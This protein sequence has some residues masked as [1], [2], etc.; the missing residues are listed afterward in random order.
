MH[1][2]PAVPSALGPSLA[3]ERLSFAVDEGEI[4]DAASRLDARECADTVQHRVEERRSLRGGRVAG[5]DEAHF[6]RQ[7][8]VAIEAR[9]GVSERQQA[10]DHHSRAH[11]QHD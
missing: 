11:Q 9:V 7:H 5:L 3:L 1:D 4:V 6:H 2:C 10:L 8:V